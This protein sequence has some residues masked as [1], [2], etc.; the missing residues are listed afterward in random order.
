MKKSLL[1][2]VTLFTA[3][4]AG[5]ETIDNKT[6]T[7][8][9]TA[10]GALTLTSGTY[11]LTASKAEG[12]TVPMHHKDGDIR[13]Y[14]KGTLTVTTTG[15]NM[16]SIV[17]NIAKTGIYVQADMSAST[18]TVTVDTTA[19]TVTWTGDANNVILTV[20]KKATYG[21]EKK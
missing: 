4:F 3:L 5:A 16:K 1:L 14:T 6:A 21:R 9:A 15:A 18:G 17:F 11:T 2:L 8:T 20:G 10:N 7:W 19:M 12:K 13:V